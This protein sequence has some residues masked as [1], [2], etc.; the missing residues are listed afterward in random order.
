M[1]AQV[2]SLCYF[3]KLEAI[4]KEIIFL[5]N[6]NQTGMQEHNIFHILSKL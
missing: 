5:W 1:E 4:S 3:I 6:W 2:K